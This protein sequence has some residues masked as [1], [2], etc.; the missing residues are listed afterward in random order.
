VEDVLR[1]EQHAKR[2]VP[3]QFVPLIG[4]DPEAPAALARR[5]A[6]AAF[7]GPAAPFQQ[8]A[9][10]RQHNGGENDEQEEDGEEPNGV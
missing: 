1:P 7:D 6:K 5:S 9:A 8:V 2:V 3:A 10:G 4:G